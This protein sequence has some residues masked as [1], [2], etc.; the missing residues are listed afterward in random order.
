MSRAFGMLVEDVAP[1]PR[2]PGVLV[3]FGPTVGIAPEAQQRLVVRSALGLP[4]VGRYVGPTH[5]HLERKGG[6]TG[7]VVSGLDGGPASYRGALVHEEGVW[8][9]P[10]GALLRAPSRP[11]AAAAR[12]DLREGRAFGLLRVDG[13]RVIVAT[14]LG[15][16]LSDSADLWRELGRIVTPDGFEISPA[17][18]EPIGPGWPVDAWPSYARHHGEHEVL[19]ARP[20]GPAMPGFSVLVKGQAL[21]QAYVLAQ[22]SQGLIQVDLSSPLRERPAFMIA[23]P[24]IAAAA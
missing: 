16:G 21:R 15:G 14:V 18:T 8:C 19:L 11:R 24:P 3:L 9:R 20:C 13:T 2:R 7:I 10:F 22:Q 6:I 12:F 17:E 5:V 1:V 23:A 4:R